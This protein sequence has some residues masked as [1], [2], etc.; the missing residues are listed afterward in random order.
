MVPVTSVTVV[1]PPGPPLQFISGVLS[2]FNGQ[3]ATGIWTLR[4]KDNFVS[5]GGSIAAFELQICSNEATNPPLIVLNNVLQPLSGNNIGIDASFLKAVDANNTPAQLTFTLV[6]IPHNG[7]LQLN[8]SN[9]QVGGQFTQADIDNGALR[10]FDFGLNAGPDDFQFVV[11][12]GEGGM[13]IGVFQISPLVG[14]KEL[15]SSLS[16]ELSPNPAD[17]VLRLSLQEPLRS[18]ALVSMYNAAG[19]QVRTWSLAAG[20]TFLTLQVSD[21][22]DGV[23]AVSIENE[24]VRGVRKVV[25]R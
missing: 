6:T 19:Q 13:A 1:K 24:A 11:S 22:P 17:A 25:L 15:L 23:Y 2:A 20:N 3:D 14:T 12:D 21:L 18:D 9:L 16:F 10:Y 5:S 7:L 4:V 8:S